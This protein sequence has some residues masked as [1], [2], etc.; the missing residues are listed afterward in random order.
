MTICIFEN[1]KSELC[2]QPGVLSTEAILLS[3]NHHNL[4]AIGICCF[5]SAVASFWIQSGRDRAPVTMLAV[6]HIAVF[7]D[8]GFSHTQ[9]LRKFSSVVKRG[10]KAEIAD[11]SRT[12]VTLQSSYQTTVKPLLGLQLIFSQKPT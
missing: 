11:V 6:A 9:K 5:L 7:L 8:G 12:E 2:Q 3:L 10:Q 4:F 1:W